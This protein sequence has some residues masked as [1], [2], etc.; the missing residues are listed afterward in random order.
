MGGTDKMSSD[1]PVGLYRTYAKLPDDEEFGYNSWC[2]S[3]A[4]GRTFL[5]GGPIIHF[6]VDGKAIGDTVA[7]S[8]PGTVE[9]E[10][11]AE[12]IFPMNVLQIVRDGEGRRSGRVHRRHAAAGAP[13]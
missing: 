9:V 8:G 12:S 2:R 10:A 5:S 3:V 6:S 4:S 13:R 7:I 11:W 1:V